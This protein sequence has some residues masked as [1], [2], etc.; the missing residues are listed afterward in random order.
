MAVDFYKFIEEI[1]K[2]PEQSPLFSPETPPVQDISYDYTK[3]I[4][5]NYYQTTET[6]E[7]APSRLPAMYSLSDLERDPEFAFRSKRFLDGIGRNENIFEF[8]RDSDFSLASAISRSFEAGKWSD[9]EKQDYVYLRNK[10]NNAELRGFKER[11]NLVKDVAGDILGDPFNYLAA[12]FAIPTFGGSIAGKAALGKAAEIGVKKYTTSQL[13]KRG[14]LL[15]AA[16]GAAFA[17]PHEYYLQDID[18]NLGA[19]DSIDLSLVGQM[20]LMG[21]GFGGL[22]GG[23]VGQI[24]GLYGRRFDKKEFKSSNEELIDKQ[25]QGKNTRK[26]VTEQSETERS[27]ASSSQNMLYKIFANTTGKPTTWFLGYVNKSPTLKK[28]LESL[29]YDYDSTLTSTGRKGPKGETYGDF[30]GNLNSKL[31]YG[32]QKS[33]NLLYGAENGLNRL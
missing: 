4:T 23:G 33:L 28:F 12:L 30:E 9:Q 29:R 14:A 18:V 1:N 8:L 21:A 7:F 26:E 10:F 32:L 16:E 24:T 6:R 25:G 27:L 20:G 3:D 15:G 22:I 13:A 31:Q 17:G 2:E 19:R 11:F 5:P